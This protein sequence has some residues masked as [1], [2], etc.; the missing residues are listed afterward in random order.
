M[1]RADKLEAALKSLAT[2]SPEQL[3]QSW[4]DLS[5]INLP[6]AS[7]SLLQHLIAHKLQEKAFGKLPAYIERELNRLSGKGEAT[8][9]MLPRGGPILPGTR[10]VREWNGKTI[11]VQ[12]TEKGFEWNDETYRSLS[13][14]ARKVTGAHWSGPRFFGLTAKAA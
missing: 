2:L 9:P 13:E 4:S 8:V 10:F 11:A 6:N 1:A 14:I 12:A 7:P 3:R 5:G